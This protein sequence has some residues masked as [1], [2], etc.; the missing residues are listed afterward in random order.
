MNDGSKLDTNIIS[1]LLKNSSEK[2]N[3]WHELLGIWDRPGD[4]REGELL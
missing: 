2:F 3:F 1:H 4:E